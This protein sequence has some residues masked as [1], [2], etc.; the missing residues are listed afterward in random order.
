MMTIYTWNAQLTVTGSC[1]H[2]E[3]SR[4]IKWPSVPSRG[5]RILSLRGGLHCLILKSPIAPPLIH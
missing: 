1:Y 3:S 4:E 5:E 2:Q